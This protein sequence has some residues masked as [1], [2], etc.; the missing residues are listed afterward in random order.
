MTIAL[1]SDI[2][3]NM[4]ALEAALADIDKREPNV[5]YCLGDLVG[6]NIWPNG[7]VGTIQ[8]RGIAT[9]AGN[10]DLKVKPKDN[11]TD[12]DIPTSGKD[13][14][15]EIVSNKAREYLLSLPAHIRLEYQLKGEKMNVLL[16]HGSPRSV[17]EYLLEDME[18]P[19]LRAIM[20]EANADILC[21]G[22]SHKPYHR[23]ITDNGR[24]RH[25]IN[26]G[27]VGKPKDGDPRSC[28]VLLHIDKDSSMQ[29]KASI[30]VDFIR[31]PY[32]IEMAAKAIETSPLPNELA[33]MLRKAY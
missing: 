33:E 15:Y 32:D 10:H 19:V 18:E 6:Y 7:V 21:F 14:A 27:S 1:F 9:I 22:H 11:N 25:A 5:I 13:Y 2:H 26:I 31:V 24:F 17:N 3:A 12:A 16:V 28:Y 20:Q 8:K 30:R 4:P 29:S 23:I